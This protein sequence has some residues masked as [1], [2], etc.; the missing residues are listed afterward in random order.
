MTGKCFLRMINACWLPVHN[1]HNRPASRLAKISNSGSLVASWVAVVALDLDGRPALAYQDLVKLRLVGDLQAELV[2]DFFGGFVDHAVANLHVKVLLRAFQ[3][4]Q[5]RS[6]L[7]FLL[8]E[9][10]DAQA[11]YSHDAYTQK[12]ASEHPLRY[13][14]LA[15]ILS[16]K[17]QNNEPKNAAQLPS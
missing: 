10:A 5:A 1:L 17:A 6:G 8:S 9:Q 12:C 7:G 11:T 16:I 15:V 14:L 3:P 4:P 2:E 13:S